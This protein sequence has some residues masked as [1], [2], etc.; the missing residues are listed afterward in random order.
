MQNSTLK[1]VHSF[2][3]RFQLPNSKLILL[4]GFLLNKI[5]IDKATYYLV[6]KFYV[7]LRNF[8]N[9]CKKKLVTKFFKKYFEK[10]NALNKFQK[11][12]TLF[13]NINLLV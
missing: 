7:Y 11:T 2:L 9:R 10:N 6:I 4:S 1:N 3:F 5:V 12:K 8:Q 13:C